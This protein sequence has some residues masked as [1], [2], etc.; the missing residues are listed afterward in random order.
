MAKDRQKWDQM[1]KITSGLGLLKIF[2]GVYL[3]VELNELKNACPGQVT[4]SSIYPPIC[5]ALGAI[6]LIRGQKIKK[7]QAADGLLPNYAQAP[8]GNPPVVLQAQPIDG[9]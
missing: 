1:V 3:F 8:D 5:I 7:L 6:W 4:I 2:A 9:K